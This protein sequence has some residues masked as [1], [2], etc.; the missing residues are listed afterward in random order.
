LLEN[1]K[2]NALNGLVAVK[3]SH[4]MRLC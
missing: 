2:T 4:L 1:D 3:H